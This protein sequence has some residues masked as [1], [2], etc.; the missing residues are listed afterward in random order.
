MCGIICAVLC[1]QFE[2]WPRVALCH[3]SYEFEWPMGGR[4]VVEGTK[5]FYIVK[6]KK[7]YCHILNRISNVARHFYRNS[8]TYLDTYYSYLH[9]IP[10]GHDFSKTTK[11]TYRM[12]LSTRNTCYNNSMNRG[13]LNRI[14]SWTVFWAI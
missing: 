13:R 2:S 1:A 12:G 8:S 11:L 7:K 10:T 6:W 9:N 14:L 3:C 5:N 4:K